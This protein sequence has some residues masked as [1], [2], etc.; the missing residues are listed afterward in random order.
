MRIQKMR[1]ERIARA[2]RAAEGNELPKVAIGYAGKAYEIGEEIV[3]PED[4]ATYRE[5]WAKRGLPVLVVELTG[6]E[7][8][9]AGVKFLEGLGAVRYG[10][11]PTSE[12]W[13]RKSIEVH[14][15]SNAEAEAAVNGAMKQ[16]YSDASLA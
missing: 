11:R 12:E 1:V 8:E 3:T 15:A 9:S 5:E 7:A 10:K 16:N 14:A 4:F 6:E 13:E 2:I